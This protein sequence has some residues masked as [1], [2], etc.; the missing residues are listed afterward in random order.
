[1]KLKK[2]EGNPILSPNPKNDW[3]NLVV[4][5]PGVFY[6]EGKFYML[7]RA[8]GDDEAHII[9][10]G[11]AISDDGYH[12]ERMSDKP[13]LGPSEEGP[14]MGCIEDARIVKFDDY[15]YV[16]YAFRPFPPGQYWKFAHDEVLTEDHGAHAPHFIKKNMANSALAM[17]KDFKNWLKLGRIT[18]S[19]LDDRDVIL[20]PEK[21]NGKYAMLHRPKEWIGEHY[22]VK[23][24]AVWIRFSDD[25]LVWNEPSHLLIDGIDGGWEEKVGGSTPPLKT[26][27]GWLVLYHGVEKGGLGYY[28]VGAV[29]LDNDDPTKVIGRTKDYIMEP[30]FDYEIEGYYKGC[31]FPTGNMIVDDTLYV[32]YGGADKYIGLATCNVNELIEFTLSEAQNS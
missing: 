20:F 29:M 4:C 25:M 11:L 32:Y 2:F 3:E 14:D 17:T 1:M 7:Y 31:V 22:G 19:N 23:N 28:R 10:F 27:K 16:T 26:D 13:V 12:F 9:R 21:I 6:D 8:A 5:N 18:D 15:Y 24:P 30:E